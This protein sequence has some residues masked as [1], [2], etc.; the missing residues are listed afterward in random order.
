MEGDFIVIPSFI[1]LFV[2]S[3]HTLEY[4]LLPGGRIPYLLRISK[5]NIQPDLNSTPPFRPPISLF[6]LVC[7]FC[8]I[9]S[10][11]HDASRPSNSK[12]TSN[13]LLSTRTIFFSIPS[14]YLAVNKVLYPPHPSIPTPSG[15]GFCFPSDQETLPPGRCSFE[16]SLTLP[17]PSYF[18]TPPKIPS[19]PLSS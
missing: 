8:P 18:L 7:G 3:A 2:T 10:A 13:L 6:H 19:I 5:T 11:N 1:R 16:P 12:K 15:A 4:D 14:A 9:C 17:H